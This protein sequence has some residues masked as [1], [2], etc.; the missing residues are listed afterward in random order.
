MHKRVIL[1]CDP[2]LDDALALLL[3]LG[4]PDE[5]ML[6]AVTTVGGNV[7][8]SSTTAN[9]LAL[10][11]LADRP[12]IPVHPGCAKPLMRPLLTADHVHGAD[13]IGGVQLPPARR[14]AE[15]LHG[16]LK[17]VELCRAA[18]ENGITLCPTGPM[19]NVA[20]ALSL[21]PDIARH[22][23]QIVFMGGVALGPGNITPSAE[24]NIHVD[25][26]AAHIVLSSGIPA[27]MMGLDVT[28]KVVATHARVD[29]IRALGGPVCEAVADMLAFYWKRTHRLEQNTGAALHDPCTIAWLIDP[30]LF[31]G[32]MCAMEVDCNPGPNYGRTV[33]D[34]WGSTGR[35]ANVFL[36]TDV[37]DDAFFDLLADRLARVP[38]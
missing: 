25:P 29:R 12:D 38:G 11:A 15:A 10:L 24:Y 30:S 28:R 5:I 23:D 27:V 16:A 36:V 18:P 7:A 37:Q 33:A 19:T 4:S 17:I 6:E 3:A 13:G 1:D 34:L 9:A 8:L 31:G 21:A 32:R 35:E 2:G 14:D 20:L 26:H 22:I